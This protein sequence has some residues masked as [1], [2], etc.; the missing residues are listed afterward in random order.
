[1]QVLLLTFLVG[2][3]CALKFDPTPCDP[4]PCKF[5][6]TCTDK[7][8]GES[9]CACVDGTT[10]NLCQTNPNDCVRP[11]PSQCNE[12][13]GKCSDK[14]N[15]FEC[16]CM[17]GFSGKNCELTPCDNG[18]RKCENDGTCERIGKSCKTRCRCKPD[19]TGENCQT[20]VNDCD[21]PGPNQCNEDCGKCV[22]GINTFTCTC[23]NGFGGKNCEITPC[24][25][26]NRVCQNGGVC[27]VIRGTCK[28]K[29]TC[30]PDFTGK[31]CET[32][33]DNCDK[34]GVSQCNE[35]CGKC[36]DGINSFTCTCMNGYSGKNCE[37]TPCDNGNRVCENGGKCIADPKT[38]STKCQC[39]P[40]FVGDNCEEKVN[41][42]A[43]K[44]CKCGECK[45]G[46]LSFTCTC[47]DG[48]IGKTCNKGGPCSGKNP[49]QNGG[50][51]II[52]GCKSKCKCVK[53]FTGPTCEDYI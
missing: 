43:N 5:G 23:M 44:P 38:C 6:G 16:T 13:C 36:V 53:F 14:I 24:M 29:C 46:I 34:P 4:N 47:K 37:K 35:N 30:K 42:C 33:I 48:W 40:D 17:N 21:K 52:D 12:N 11:G 51:C 39:K 25:N 1:M 9:E 22:D 41:D 45:D 50:V 7:G 8:Y 26:G 31:D 18:N 15:G 3:A 20:K 27:S 19:F 49:C 10:G 2:C 28:T 32:K